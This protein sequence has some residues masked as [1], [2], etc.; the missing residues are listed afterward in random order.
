[1]LTKKRS[2]RLKKV[3]VTPFEVKAALPKS[4][5]TVSAVATSIAKS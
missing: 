1:V 3:E 2:S 5:R 4:P